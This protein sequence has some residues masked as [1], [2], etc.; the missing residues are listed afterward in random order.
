MAVVPSKISGFFGEIGGLANDLAPISALSSLFGGGDEVNVSQSATN[1]TSVNLTNIL[2]NQSP[3]NTTTDT[4]GGATSSAS[5]AASSSGQGAQPA[6][7]AS[8]G[9]PD[10]YT[11]SAAD[12]VSQNAGLGSAGTP[13]IKVLLAIGA[14]LSVVA[15]LFTRKKGRK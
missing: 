9:Y 15:F 10:T 13:D 2:S 1:T 12:T 4:K 6:P 11:G 5:S 14:G 3:G 8:I 7:V